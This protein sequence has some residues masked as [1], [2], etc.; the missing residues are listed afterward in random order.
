MQNDIL[1][2]M[3]WSR[4]KNTNKYKENERIVRAWG[5]RWEDTSFNSWIEYV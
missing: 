1:L 5:D 4:I 2:H 3:L